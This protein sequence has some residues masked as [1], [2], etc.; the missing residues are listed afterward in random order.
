MS[1]G[2]EVFKAN[3]EGDILHLLANIGLYNFC[4]SLSVFYPFSAA[5][6]VPVASD[7]PEARRRVLELVKRLGYQAVDRGPLKAARHIESVPLLLMP[8]WRTPL[9]LVTL[10]WLLHYLLLLFK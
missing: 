7:W 6:Q 1:L 9:L 8:S 2:A 5:R 3:M 10:L 4:T